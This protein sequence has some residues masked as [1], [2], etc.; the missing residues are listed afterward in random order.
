MSYAEAH[1]H[2]DILAT[3][4]KHT[5]SSHEDGVAQVLCGPGGLEAG[6]KCR[7]LIRG[8]LVIRH[9][10]RAAAEIEFEDG[11]PRASLNRHSTANPLPDLMQRRSLVRRPPCPRHSPGSSSHTLR[12]APG[13]TA[14]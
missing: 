2:P 12:R 8:G 3:V 9:R 5:A 14:S 11:Q 10:R 13:E 4:T 6:D 7:R 1:A